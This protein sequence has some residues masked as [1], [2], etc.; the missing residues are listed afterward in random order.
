MGIGSNESSFRFFILLS[1]SSFS[2]KS[3]LLNTVKTG[4]PIAPI[5][6]IVSKLHD[7]FLLIS[8]SDSFKSIT[9]MIKSEKIVSSRVEWK[10]LINFRGRRSIKPTVSVNRT[11]L[12]ENLTA[13]VVVE[14]V[15]NNAS[16]TI[17]FSS[18]SKLNNEL[19]PALV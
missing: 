12:L 17:T 8:C 5:C 3:I 19:F 14:R 1:T 9:S 16:S 15:V 7:I 13:L 6:L 4:M 18:V 10:A 2:I 11:L